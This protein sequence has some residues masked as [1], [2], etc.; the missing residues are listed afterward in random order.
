MSYLRLRNGKFD[1]SRPKIMGILNVTPD[2]F[3]DGGQFFDLDKAL[4]HA[5]EMIADGADILDIGGESTRP[6]AQ[7][8]SAEQELARIIPVIQ[9]VRA[10]SDIP[11]SVDTQKAEVMQAAIAAGV[12][13]IND[14]R[15]LQNDGAL[16]IVA[17]S[18]VAVCLM[19]MQ[20]EPD[21]MQIAPH[22]VDVVG[23][24]ISFLAD[25]VE[26]CRLAG[27]SDDRIIVDPGF[28]FGKT[29]QHN[30]ELL[31]HLGRL[32][33][34]GVPVLAGMSRKKMIRE[35][36]DCHNES[37]AAGSVAAA[38]LAAIRGARIL[39]VHDVKP[40]VQALKLVT[41]IEWMDS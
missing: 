32:T 1:L 7:E 5:R 20:G 21:T 8:V 11:L 31:K 38:V 9:A 35:L 25:R 17:S 13:I 30:L 2:S 19:H 26:A 6:G 29:L 12:D 41:A 34:L 18:K 16:A 22:Y 24:V 14:V 37:S 28:G 23:E 15:A 27:I 3:S 33:S 39:R 40:T 4:K 10:I 36:T